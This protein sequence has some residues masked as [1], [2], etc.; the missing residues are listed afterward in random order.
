MRCYQFSRPLLRRSVTKGTRVA[1]SHLSMHLL[2]SRRNITVMIIA[3]INNS[4]NNTYYNGSNTMEQ[5]K[6]SQRGLR[7]L[8][9]CS[10]AAPAFKCH[11]WQHSIQQQRQELPAHYFSSLRKSFR[12]INLQLYQEGRSNIVLLSS[13]IPQSHCHSP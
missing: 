3:V 8:F 10:S 9:S 2:N 6:E 1:V 7:N 11:R 5:L 13:C 4:Q 12:M